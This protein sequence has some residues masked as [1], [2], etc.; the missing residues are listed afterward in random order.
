MIRP[1]RTED[2]AGIMDIGNRAWQPIYRMFNDVY[3]EELL[4]VI[5][6]DTRTCKGE[7]IRSHCAAH[8]EWTLVCE[9]NGR[10]VGFVTFVLDPNRKIGT[11]GNNAVDPACGLKGKGQEMYQAALR[12]FRDNGMLYASVRTGLD[13]AHAPARRAYERAGFDIR[14]DDV[15]YYMKL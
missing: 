12:F 11:I 13:D 3:G 7:Q 14:H 10:V 6:G 15:T 9:E 1:Y 4:G 2:L 5:S 8:P